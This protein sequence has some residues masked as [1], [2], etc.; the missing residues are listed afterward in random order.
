MSAF[1]SVLSAQVT[2]SAAPDEDGVVWK[3]VET[4]HFTAY[5]E[6]NWAPSG[7]VLELERIHSTLNMNMSSFAGWISGGKITL[8][9]YKNES[10]YLKSHFKPMKWA[11]AI[12]LVGGAPTI[13]LY[14]YPD[15]KEFTEVVAHESTHLILG[16]YFKDAPGA[17]PLWLNEGMAIFNEDS[18]AG[19]GQGAW[20][21]SLKYKGADGFM[22]TEKFVETEVN[23][24]TSSTTV[25][26]WY[27]QAYATVQFL[28]RPDKKMQFKVFMLSVKEGMPFRDAVWKAYRYSS[29]RELDNDFKAWVKTSS[30]AAKDTGFGFS[31]SGFVPFETGY[32]RFNNREFTRPAENG[33]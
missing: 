5:Y 18:T 33:Q 17:L 11:R 14:D 7:L 2:T 31:G 28:Y 8:Y 30:R 25:Q 4:P 20:S 16:D 29:L 22:P 9:I 15:R 23:A 32:S 24:D 1:S 26:M 12:A 27:L 6:K 19:L 10:S 13:V 21:A 3:K